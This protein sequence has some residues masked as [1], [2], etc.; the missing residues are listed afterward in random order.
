MKDEPSAPRDVQP[1]VLNGIETV[2]FDLDGTLYDRHGLAKRMVRRLWWCL[3]LMAI[4]RKAKGAVWRWIVHTRWHREVYLATM[5]EL[6]GTTCPRR[7]D[8]IALAEECH[9]RGLKTAIYSDYGAVEAKLQALK[10]DKGLFEKVFT[11]P[12]LGGLKPSK[13]CAE[14]VLRRMGAKPETTLFVGDRE[15]KD[16]VAAKNVGA[17]FLSVVSR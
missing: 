9:R 7:E 2:I 8:V 12:D 15:E 1:D 13:A 4:D 17:R 16:G 3:P 5:S 10:V 6:I 11:A 14:E